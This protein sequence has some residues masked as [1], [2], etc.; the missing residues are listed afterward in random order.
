MK[1]NPGSFG[2]AILM[3]IPIVA[4]F[5]YFT[6]NLTNQNALATVIATAC[7]VLIW[8]A[9]LAWLDRSDRHFQES[10]QRSTTP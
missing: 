3:M 5:A 9:L 8:P 6:Y 7:Y 2:P 10:N 1:R 4:V